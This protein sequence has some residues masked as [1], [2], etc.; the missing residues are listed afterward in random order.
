M[1]NNVTS[2]ME[3]YPLCSM[4]AGML[5]KNKTLY[6]YSER[7]VTAFFSFL[8]TEKNTF[9]VCSSAV[10]KIKPIN[11]LKKRRKNTNAWN[12]DGIGIMMKVNIYFGFLVYFFVS[13][14]MFMLALQERT[15][16]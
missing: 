9:L 11:L 5:V 8:L 7:K 4:I 16:I 2:F 6:S 3:L 10:Q 12:Y 14:L 15:A 13:L 1:H